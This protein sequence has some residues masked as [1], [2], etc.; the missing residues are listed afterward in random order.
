MFDFF[1]TYL[2]YTLESS[3][4]P[5]ILTFPETPRKVLHHSSKSVEW[6]HPTYLKRLA[7]LSQEPL[8][9][10]GD[11]LHHVAGRVLHQA[12]LTPLLI[13]NLQREHL[14]RLPHT[15]P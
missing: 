9:V 14:F 6:D 11:L 8:N 12:E 5:L 4:K 2:H 13:V 10:R 7:L 3:S 15:S 1:V